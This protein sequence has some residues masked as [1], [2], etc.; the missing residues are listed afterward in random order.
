MKLLTLLLLIIAAPALAQTT[1]CNPIDLDY[2]YNFEQQNEGVS[3]RSGADPVI[4]RHK[5]DYYLFVT[6]QGGYWRSRDLL[7][8]QYISPSRW[9]MEDMCAPAAVSVRDT[10]YLFQSTFEQ[11]PILYSTAPQTGKLEF[12]NRWLPRLPKDIGPWD[13]ALFHD[14]DTEK[15]YMYWGSSNVYPIFG[16]E[17]DK[18]RQLSYADRNVGTV[19]KPM[20]WLD[21]WQHGWERFGPN[22]ADLVKP[23]TEGAWLTKHNKKYYLQYG[24]P[25]T[26]YNV[27]ANGTYVSHSPLGPW[28]YAP[29]NPIA[30]HPGGYAVGCGHGNTFQD[31][32]GNYWNTGTSWIGLVWGMERRIVMHPAGFDRDDQLY[33]DTRFGDWPHKLPTRTWNTQNG[34]QAED[35]FTGWMLLNYKKPVVA[36]STLDTLRAENVCDENARTFWATRNV[37]G[38]TLT[39]DLGREQ[40]LRA[41]QVNYVDHKNTIFKS[42]ASVYTQFRLLGSADG[43]RWRTLADLTDTTRYPRRDRACAYVELPHRGDGTP[44]KARYVRYEHVY[45]AGPYLAINGLRIFGNGEGSVPN[46]PAGLTAKRQKDDRNADLSWQPV[47]GATGYNIRWG[48]APDKLYQTYQFWADDAPTAGKPFELRALNRGVPYYFA[49]EAFNENG[50]SALSAVVSDGFMKK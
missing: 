21:P 26:E 39:I 43:K 22:H 6:I 46:V 14:P 18:N 47:P 24:A 3:Y 42:D 8:W 10:L 1:Y 35:T 30:Y 9:P 23:F 2:K 5:Q 16:A 32:Y 40:T 44:E 7:N 36:S 38:Q 11:R 34:P 20:F 15:W 31:A 19:G 33:A 28:E 25:G 45:T 13:P 48:I 49:I 29:Y 37:P 41:V 27:Y 12:Y 17:L 50:V 4:I